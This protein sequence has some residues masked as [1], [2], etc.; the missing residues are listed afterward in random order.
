MK[1]LKIT[2]IVFTFTLFLAFTGVAAATSAGFSDV[3][4]KRMGG[5]TLISTHHKENDCAQ[6]VWKTASRDDWSGDDRAIQAK[7]DTSSGWTDLVTTKWV[8]IKDS[9]AY[10][11]GVDYSLYLRAKKSTLSTVSFWG[12]WSWDKDMTVFN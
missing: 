7:L 9:Y 10:F 5:S 12:I 8:A 3:T 6:T 1:L 2:A 4:I 11:S